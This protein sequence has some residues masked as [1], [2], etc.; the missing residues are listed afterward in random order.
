MWQR[1]LVALPRVGQ[2]RDK[3]PWGER[4][5]SSMLKPPDPEQASR[6]GP[7]GEDL[8][9]EEL[10]HAIKYADDKER[11]VGLLAAPFAA[12]IGII[13]HS[14]LISRDLMVRQADGRLGY[15]TN[16]TYYHDV[17]L[18]LLVLSV[19]M[20]VT[21]WF[22]KRLF[23]GVVLVLY[24]ITVFNLRHYF[25]FAIPYVLVAAWLLVRSF[26]LQRQVREA[27]TG[28]AGSG[29]TPGKGSSG[30]SSA[31]PGTSKRYTPPVSPPKRPAVRKPDPKDGRKRAG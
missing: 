2:Q 7:P 5:R 6:A 8:S 27:T 1:L 21:A 25:G 20:V 28:G 24:G 15:Q 13:I 10:E 16:P 12:I 26:R 29:R 3:A 4:L 9:V 17:L 30:G 22:R 11:L 18:V 19:L 31:R 14:D 23:L